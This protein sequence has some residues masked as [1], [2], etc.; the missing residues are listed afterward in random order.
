[1]HTKPTL[2]LDTETTGLNPK[3]QSIIEIACY[4][5][6]GPLPTTPHFHHYVNTDTPIEKGAQKVHGITH[7]M[8]KDKP[9]FSELADALMAYITGH[10]VVIHNAPF[11]VA[12]IN[13]ELK[14]CGHRIK[15]IRKICTI[16]DSLPIARKTHPHQKNNLDA[17][18]KR[19]QIDGSHR[20]LHGALLDTKLLAQVY[21]AMIETQSELTPNLPETAPDYHCSTP[22][23]QQQPH[24]APTAQEKQA[25]Q[26]LMSLLKDPISAQAWAINENEDA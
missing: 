5:T 13:Q 26:T 14:R 21:W 12:F 10:T 22:P 19:Y 24:I 7:A 20:Q 6:I 17:L 16:I 25:H 23:P 9:K 11:D 1:M 8:L 4:Q 18:C 3:T 15:D 2:F